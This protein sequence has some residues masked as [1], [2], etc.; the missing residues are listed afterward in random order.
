LIIGP[1]SGGSDFQPKEHMFTAAIF[2][3][4]LFLLM[5]IL[6]AISRRK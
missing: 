6:W 5:V 4:I 2:I 1:P 3:A